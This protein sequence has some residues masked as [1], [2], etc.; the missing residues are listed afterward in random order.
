MSQFGGNS[1][2]LEYTVCIDSRNRD[3]VCYPEPNDFKVDVNFSRGLPVQRIYLGSIEL[4][5]PQYIIEDEWSQF[6]MSEGFSINATAGSEIQ[7]QRTFAIQD[8]SATGMAI[9]AAEL[10]VF[11]NPIVSID[12]SLPNSPVFETLYTHNLDIRQLWSWGVPMRLIST[13]LSDPEWIDLT[14]Q[15]AHLV[16]LSPTTFQLLDTPV[17]VNSTGGYLLAPTIPNPQIMAD[18]ITA[19]LH[20]NGGSQFSVRFDGTTNQFCVKRTRPNT[21]S[22]YR[23]QSNYQSN[24]QPNCQPYNQA[25]AVLIVDNSNNER[26]LTRVMGFGCTNL[27]FPPG[28]CSEICGHYGY[29]CMSYLKLTAGNYNIESFPVEFYL[30]ANR[31]YFTTPCDP[32]APNAIPPPVFVFSDACGSCFSVSTPEGFTYGKYSSPEIFAKTLQDGMNLATGTSDY[33]VIYQTDVTG[34]FG[35]FTFSTVSGANFGLEFE[36]SRNVGYLRIEG[37]LREMNIADRL[38]FASLSYRGSNSY[39]SHVPFHMPS[40]TGCNGAANIARYLSNVYY[41]LVNRKKKQFGIQA[42]ATRSAY[43]D[44]VDNGDGTAT[45]TTYMTSTFIPANLLAHGFQLGDIVSI[46]GFQVTVSAVPAT[47]YTFVIDLAGVSPALVTGSRCVSL[48]GPPIAN[49]FFGTAP[50]GSNSGGNSSSI[51][52]E[53]TGFPADA[54]LW[55][56]SASMPFYA[57]HQFNLD[58]PDYLLIQI[59]EPNESRYIQHRWKSDTLTNLFGKLVVYP[60]LRLERAT[61][62]ESVFQGLQLVNSLHFRILTPDH[63]L[64][65]FH[66]RNWSATLIF[67]VSAKTGAQVCY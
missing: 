37:V 34:A 41:P 20:L 23:G 9:Y 60:A 21:L 1:R 26:C 58:P 67:V 7:C 62:M 29:Q 32:S 48:F 18:I 6:Y 17:V 52:A 50:C 19:S 42:V 16:I 4:P 24:G 5:L 44:V 39:T 15:N 43:A 2:P 8:D 51:K 45:V 35:S 22:Y 65:N 56:D 63:Q 27:P 10:P 14:E 46:N 49:L 54:V 47:A 53:I 30:Q 66:G 57:P 31:F 13:N 33:V 40:T 3:T 12:N 59:T 11:L 38:G 25:T 64:Y 55:W 36:D 28:E 61:P